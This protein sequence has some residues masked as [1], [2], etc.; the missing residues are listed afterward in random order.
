MQEI[1]KAIYN[2]F[3]GNAALKAT[4]YGN[5]SESDS[6]QV[7]RLFFTQAP[8]NVIFPYVIFTKVTSIPWYSFTTKAE[9][10]TYQFTIYS[11][12]AGASEIENIFT[13]LVAVFDDCTLAY[14]N[15]WDALQCTREFDN[16]DF[17]DDVWHW[18][19]RYR[20]ELRKDK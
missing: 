7:T 19:I 17:V 20:I 4:V 16:T 13:K 3:I 18:W 1:R 11:S 2:K 10:T 12:T 15:S 8:Q 14:E 9:N 6:T 5:L